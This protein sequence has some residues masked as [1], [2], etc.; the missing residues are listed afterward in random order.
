MKNKRVKLLIAHDVLRRG[1]GKEMA[2]VSRGRNFG[3]SRINAWKVY[4]LGSFALPS[5]SFV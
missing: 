2:R 4:T 5:L 1:G 3:V